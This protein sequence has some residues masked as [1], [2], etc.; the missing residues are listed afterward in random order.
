MLELEQVVKRYEAAGEEVR[1]VAGIS[2]RVQPGEMVA[3]Q[4]PSGSGKTTLL[5]LI[6][7]LI[8]ADAGAIRFAGEEIGSLSED[9]AA[10]YL[11]RDVGFIY[12]TVQLMART[13]A[14]E[15]AA[16]KLLLG[17]VGMRE[18]QARTLPWLE[19][20][21]LAGRAEHTPEQL[22]GGERQRIAIARAL[23]GEPRLILADEPTG[24]LDS[25]ASREVVR[26]LHS[27]A[28]EQGASVL[29]VTHD[30]E[31]AQ[32]ADRRYVLRDGRLSD[33][34]VA[35]EEQEQL[36]EPRSESTEGQR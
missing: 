4:G 13:S 28:G 26:L 17:G 24:N 6:A 30:S 5:L 33:A 10:E 15:N 18:A 20:L 2:L 36:A 21:V 19:R 1:A 35:S 34:A 8:A 29:L 25:A 11:M 7:G 9:Q 14:L 22:S 16:L 3:L 12:Q 23:V 31:A 32:L 27:V